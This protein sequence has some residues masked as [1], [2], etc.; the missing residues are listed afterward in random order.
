MD[1]MNV[2]KINFEPIDRSDPGFFGKLY[3][4]DSIFALVKLDVNLN[5]AANPG[6]IFDKINIFQQ[7]VPFQQNIFMPI[8]YRVFVEGNVLGM[9]KFGFE[10]N[11]IFYD[12]KINENIDDDFFD[13]AIVKVMPDA[14]KK[15]STFW[16]STQSIPNTL[17]EI[18]A[19]KRIDSLE[20]I[21]RTFWDDFSILSSSI[22]LSDNYSI[23]GPMGL[24]NFNRVEGHVLNLGVNVNEEFDDRLN[25]NLDFSYGFSDKKIK[26]D[27]STRYYLGEYRTASIAVSAYNKITDLFG[28]S[29]YYNNLT[30]TLTNLLGKYDFRDYYYTKGWNFKIAGWIFPVLNFGLGFSNRTDISAISNSDFSIFNKSKQYRVN[31]T[32]YDTK[33]NSL[34]ASF[35]LDFRNYVEDGYRR[36]RITENKPF[37]LLSGDAVFSNKSFLKSAMDF[38]SY[39][40]QL[41]GRFTTFN[42]AAMYFSATGI[43]S[44]GP[45]PYQMLF[46]LPGNIQN[47]SKTNSFRTLTIG[48]IYGDRGVIL[49]LRHN[50][51][52]E[53]FRLLKIPVIKDWQLNL[54]G[55]LNAAIMTISPKSKTIL[56]TSYKEFTHPFYEI[57]FGIGQTMIP[58]T[59]EFSWR[60]NYTG[61]NNFVISINTFVL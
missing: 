47:A 16:K 60:L 26:T 3:I 15:D 44:D 27:F 54:T 39:K 5:N 53:L 10:L 35:L 1:N 41:F 59:L 55:Y 40:L 50:F 2:F 51:N 12:Y 18:N 4:A 46:A 11:T 38:N 25:G 7:Y 61:K 17:D 49:N 32:I 33:I 37:A 57:G 56:S 30:S 36:L 13:M 9:A 28:E 19:Y 20:A 23:T 6:R 52:D 58:L 8:D 45:I 14:D 24:Y 48:E 42:S 21:P 34:S 22:K 31:P 29:N 43:Y